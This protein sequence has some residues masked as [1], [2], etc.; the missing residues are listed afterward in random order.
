M[1]GM[2]KFE[3]KLDTLAE[4]YGEML[5][6]ARGEVEQQRERK[7]G[8]PEGKKNT[9][10]GGGVKMSRKGH[11]EK[12]FSKDKNNI[13]V[14]YHEELI[15]L[16]DMNDVNWTG[17]QLARVYS[18]D[19]KEFQQ[20][21]ENV[22][23]LSKSAEE[24]K[25]FHSQFIVENSRGKKYRYIVTIEGNM[26]GL[27]TEKIDVSANKKFKDKVSEERKN[28]GQDRKDLN[29]RIAAPEPERRFNTRSLRADERFGGHSDENGKMAGGSRGQQPDGER[30]SGESNRIEERTGERKV[31]RSAV[32]RDSE[33]R[34]LTDSPDTRFSA[35]G[36]EAV[37]V[38]NRA[39]YYEAGAA[40]AAA[41]FL[42]RKQCY[43]GMSRAEALASAY[44]D[45]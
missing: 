15:D 39:K 5:D 35:T 24:G 44:L 16:G 3:G 28:G 8:P 37:A 30:H 42:T 43:E 2:N 26:Y 31:K 12:T 22:Q 21:H 33:G 29:R 18:M 27:V 10:T 14:F 4:E 23:K 7:R 19:S 11:T 41:A 25:M 9:A 32:A 1:G 6:T 34:E 45:P 38:Q 40:E 13:G 17:R 36:T 20:F